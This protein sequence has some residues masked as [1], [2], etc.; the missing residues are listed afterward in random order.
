VVGCTGQQGGSVA[1]HLLAQGWAVRGLTRDP[2]RAA[3]HRLVRSG[4]EL[5]TG[6]LADPVAVSRLVRGAVALF[7]VTDHW[8]LGAQEE[9]RCGRAVASMALESGVAHLVYS[10]LPESGVRSG[11]RLH[12]PH[13]E[14]KARLE[15]ELVA[16]GAPASFVQ[17]STYY[18]NWPTRRLRRRDDASWYFVLPH[19]E[20]PLPAVAAA[21]LGGVVAGLLRLGPLAHGRVVRVVGDLMPAADYAR[22]LTRSL[23]VRVD[24]EHVPYEEFRTLPI[25]HAAALADMLEFSRRYH[26]DPDADLAATRALFGGVRTFESW[27]NEDGVR[28]RFLRVINESKMTTESV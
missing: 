23:G 8:S 27:A 6:D 14:G 4:A 7:L 17:L 15:A 9:Y 19:R 25:P 16:E 5:V 24:F 28:E 3:A 10:S 11:G 22:V 21:D 20:E 1:R 18:E 13:H 12:L 26:T 2:G